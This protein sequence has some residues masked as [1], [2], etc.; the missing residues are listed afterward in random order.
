M[1]PQDFQPRHHS[2]AA[3]LLPLSTFPKTTTMMWRY[4]EIIKE[5]K[6]TCHPLTAGA[7]ELLAR[8]SLEQQ[9]VEEAQY[10]VC[11]TCVMNKN[12]TCIITPKGYLHLAR[13]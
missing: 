3:T 12:K 11:S 7:M 5:I 2:S 6:D 13:H 10:C 9:L 4:K 8:E 1:L